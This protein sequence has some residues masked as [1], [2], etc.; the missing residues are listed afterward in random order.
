MKVKLF[1]A[2]VAF[3][4]FSMAQKK[5]QGYAY[6]AAGAFAAKSGANFYPSFGVGVTNNK[7][8]SVGGAFYWNSTYLTA[9]ADFRGLFSTGKKA[10]P[11]F[12]IQ[13]GLS[14]Y[15]KNIGSGNTMIALRGD[16]VSMAWPDL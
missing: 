12:C 15:N 4:L 2:L 16:F 10:T 7:N 8:V 13:P 3:P 14:T 5:G 11:F 9:H 1:L 6:L